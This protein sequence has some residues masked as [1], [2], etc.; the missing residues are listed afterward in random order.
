MSTIAI[1]V[2]EVLLSYINGLVCFYYIVYDDKIPGKPAI[3]ADMFRKYHFATDL[4]CSDDESK[5]LTDA[6]HASKV[7]KRL[8]PVRGSVRGLQTLKARGHKLCVVTSRELAVRDITVSMLNEIYPT[9]FEP[10]DIHFGNQYGDSGEKKSKR[11]MCME[12]EADILIDDLPRHVMSVSSETKGI[13]FGNYPW[14]EGDY[15]VIRASDWADVV[16][17]VDALV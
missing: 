10:E 17:T 8:P 4:E 13:L 6:F 2:D 9:I 15:D 3:T 11:Q 5:K 7:F 1:D 12:I 14:N 16:K